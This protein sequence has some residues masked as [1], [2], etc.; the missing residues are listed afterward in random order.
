MGLFSRFERVTRPPAGSVPRSPEEVRAALLGLNRAGAPWTIRAG[1]PKEKAD[2]VAHWHV[3]DPAWRAYFCRVR[4]D[5]VPQTRMRLMPDEHQVRC[6]DYQRQLG[7]E[8][9]A[10]YTWGRGQYRY[11]SSAWTLERGPDGKR[12]FER[13]AR[14]DT[15]DLKNPLR[16]A[17]LSVGWSWRAR[18]SR[19]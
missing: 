1:L 10:L 11:V 5:S 6:L 13:Q 3:T 18:I 9:G 15:A 7:N 2:L 19:L 16:D 14:T 12:R 4:D 8:S 17:V